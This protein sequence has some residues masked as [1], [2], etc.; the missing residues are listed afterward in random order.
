MKKIKRLLCILCVLSMI[1]SLPVVA[2][3]ITIGNESFQSMTEFEISTGEE[4]EVIYEIDPNCINTIETAGTNQARVIIGEDN[5][6]PI[7]FADGYPSR[8]IGLVKTSFENDK[9]AYGTGF[10]VGSD[11]VL[12]SAHVV[13]SKKYGKPINISF[14]PGLNFDGTCFFEEPYISASAINAYCP[15]NWSKDFDDNY[16]WCLLKLSKPLGNKTNSLVCFAEDNLKGRKVTITG[17]A[18]DYYY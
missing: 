9:G 13:M 8:C 1:T 18:K 7:D 14:T 16:D 12:T 3:D 10:V 2:A 15:T 17:Y 5:R 6:E 11:L 4:K